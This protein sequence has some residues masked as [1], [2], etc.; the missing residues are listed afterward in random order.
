[1]NC[2]ICG[3]EV[4]MEVVRATKPSDWEYR[5][6]SVILRYWVPGTDTI[7][8]CRLKPHVQTAYMPPTELRPPPVERPEIVEDPPPEWDDSPNRTRYAGE[9]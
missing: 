2:L 4:R 3:D 7:H 5:Y 6:Q 9:L 1:M 8:H